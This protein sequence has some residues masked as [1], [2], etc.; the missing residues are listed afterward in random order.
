MA[1]QKKIDWEAIESAYRAGVKSVNSIAKANGVAESTIRK[2]AKKFGWQRDLTKS[3]LAATKS[4]LARGDRAKCEV[5]TDTD[6]IEEASDE[7]TQVVFGHRQHIAEWRGIAGKLAVTLGEMDVDE[8]NHNEFARSLNSGVDALGK[9]IKLERQTFGMDEDKEP[10]KPAEA[11]LSNDELDAE[12]AKLRAK[13][14][15]E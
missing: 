1:E 8:S 2:R 5:R 7:I 11:S 12:I 4:K 3:V 14:G 9:L 6:I 15:N 10:E 13:V